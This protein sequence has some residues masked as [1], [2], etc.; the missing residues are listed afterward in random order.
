MA[1]C[2]K[3]DRTVSTWAAKCEGCGS[4]A[5]TTTHQVC[6][7]IFFGIWGVAVVYALVT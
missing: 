4:P 2:K 5:P 7:G 3:C 1:T 6:W